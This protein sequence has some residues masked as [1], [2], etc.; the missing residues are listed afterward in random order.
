[1]TPRFNGTDG[2]TGWVRVEVGWVF[3]EQGEVVV[4]QLT[5]PRKAATSRT[6]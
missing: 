2:Y 1:M 6:E 4:R 5:D 3:M